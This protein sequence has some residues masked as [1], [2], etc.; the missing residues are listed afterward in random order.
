MVFQ[1]Y[2][3]PCALQKN[4]LSI[5]RVKDKKN[6]KCS[7]SGR[8]MIVATM[9]NVCVVKLN[10]RLPIHLLANYPI[11]LIKRTVQ[12]EVGKFF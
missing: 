5:V 1:K 3:R 2:L 4:S 7:S 12:I 6:V 8:P 9:S 10:G 11:L